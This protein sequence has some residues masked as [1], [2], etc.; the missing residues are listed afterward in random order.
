MADKNSTKTKNKKNAGWLKTF[1]DA[2]V[3]TFLYLISLLPFPILYFISDI[4]YLLIR[5]VFRYR[6]KVIR[7]NII[8]AF[9][10]KSEE[11]IK[12][13]IRKFYIHLA[14][15]I[16][17]TIKLRT[18]STKQLDKR[19]S[20]KGLD[21]I[22]KYYAEKKSII[23]LGMH[24]NNWEW[25]SSMLKEISHRGIMIYNPVRGNKSIEKFLIRSRERWGGKCIPVDKALRFVLEFHR[26]G[27]PT[28]IWL[29][30]DQ[31]APATSGFWTYFLNR[32]APFFSGP[33][34]I[35][36][37]TNQPVFF[38]Q[39]HKTGRGYYEATFIPLIERPEEVKP[40]EIL[41][42]YIRKMEEIIRAEPEYYL[43]SHRRWKHKR[44]P[45]IKLTT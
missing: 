23:M 30:A 17:E 1:L 13:I 19:L 12:V 9:P 16:M 31:T 44:P 2:L 10:D 20:Y 39:I 21:L 32:E 4:L 42:T 14:D 29:G 11:E 7:E 25:I 22:D 43:W 27:I 15:L 34:K 38:L 33:E 45:E 3:T 40:K 26:K 5:Y 35:A 37:K 24:H 36:A 28:G 8:H 18:I 6:R 41:L